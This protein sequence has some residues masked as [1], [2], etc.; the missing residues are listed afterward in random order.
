MGEYLRFAESSSIFKTICENAPEPNAITA[1]KELDPEMTCPL[2]LVGDMLTMLTDGLRVH[3][4]VRPIY[5]TV[6]KVVRHPR[7]CFF[8]FLY[9]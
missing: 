8:F 6:Q 9:V 2:H 4:R 5:G 7:V 1:L 3:S